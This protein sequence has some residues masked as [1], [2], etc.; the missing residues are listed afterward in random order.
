MATK[1]VY[2][3]ICCLLLASMAESRESSLRS[4]PRLR[5]C[6]K[7]CDTGEEAI[8]TFCESIPKGRLFKR[9][10]RACFSV[11]HSEP[12]VCKKFCG[13]FLSKRG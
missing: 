9:A 6:V 13:R 3:F 11:V 5:R 2:L 1:F 12:T 8:E 10:R 4:Y 7:T